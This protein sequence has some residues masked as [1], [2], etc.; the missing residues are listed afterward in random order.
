MSVQVYSLLG[1]T[2]GERKDF[3]RGCK[4]RDTLWDY[5]LEHLVVIRDEKVSPF[6]KLEK[7]LLLLCFLLDHLTNKHCSTWSSMINL[8]IDFRTIQKQR[9]MLSARQR[10]NNCLEHL[11]ENVL[12]DIMLSYWPCFTWKF[13]MI[14]FLKIL[15]LI[16]QK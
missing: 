8:R 14:W 7:I 13:F 10:S 2:E 12:G 16:F 15:E 11:K 5:A 3:F 6:L 4:K 9:V 1:Q